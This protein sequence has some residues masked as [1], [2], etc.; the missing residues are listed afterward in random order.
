MSTLPPV[1]IVIITLNEEKRL[2]RLLEQLSKQSF[3]NFEIIISDSNSTDNTCHIAKQ[4]EHLGNR[5]VVHQ[6]GCTKWPWYGRNQW[7]RQAQKDLILFL[8]ADTQ[9]PS[10]TFLEKALQKFVQKKH[11]L[12]GFFIASS[13]KHPLHIFWCLVANSIR[14]T[15]QF[16]KH[17][18]LS[19]WCVLVRKSV[20]HALWGFS[21][22]IYLGED[23]AYAHEAKKQWYSFSILPY[24]YLFDMRRIEQ[25]WV[26]TTVWA[27]LNVWYKM[28][29]KGK[30][31]ETTDKKKVDYTFWNYQ[32]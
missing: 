30:F 27:Y 4:Y 25:K 29:K 24:T 2:P 17:P 16:T 20:H 9:L 26:Y 19:G 22:H 1:S 15:A 31:A 3:Q 7:A 11:D 14:H 28:L 8:D 18:L 21:T 6:C 5:F 23:S 32:K 10:S 13:T 12:A